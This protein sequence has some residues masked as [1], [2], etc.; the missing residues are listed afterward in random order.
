MSQHVHYVA[1]GCEHG[2]TSDG[3]SLLPAI[4]ASKIT[5]FNEKVRGS[6]IKLF[7]TLSDRRDKSLFAESD[8]GAMLLV[9]VPFT[10]SV[11][12]NSICIS[13]GAEGRCPAKVKL[14]INREDIDF[15]LAEDLP[16]TQTIDLL[17]D[18]DADLFHPLR[19]SKFNNVMHLTILLEGNLAAA[20]D[21]FVVS[22]IG[23]KGVITK[24]CIRLCSFFPFIFLSSAE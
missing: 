19:V 9:H 3:E 10:C 14:F 21:D 23:L 17:R 12:I 18:D 15:S 20:D 24:V 22:F 1:C 5:A 7:K 4:D 16:P 11:R 6:S 2:E 13:G 8:G